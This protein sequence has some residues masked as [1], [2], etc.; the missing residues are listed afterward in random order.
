MLDDNFELIASAEWEHEAVVETHCGNQVVATTT[1]LALL[2]AACLA[3]APQ[4]VSMRSVLG[5]CGAFV[6][7]HV[8]VS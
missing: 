3:L 2:C 5:T 4:R 6:T 8:R 7:D 1:S